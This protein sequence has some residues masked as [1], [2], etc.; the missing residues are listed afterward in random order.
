MKPALLVTILLAAATFTAVAAE[1]SAAPEPPKDPFVAAIEDLGSTDAMVRRRGAYRLGDL[2]NQKGAEPLIKALKD[3]N[4]FVRAGAISSLEK[5]RV[6]EAGTLIIKML[7]KD[8]NAQVR[9]QAA[10]AFANL[11]AEGKVKALIKALDDEADGVRYAAA[12]TLGSLRAQEAAKRLA[13]LLISP[14]E[15]SGM[16]RAAAGALRAIRSKETRLSLER[17]LAD[18]D[19][20]VRRE[21][22]QALAS[23]GTKESLPSLKKLL[24]DEDAQVRVLTAQTLAKFGDLSGITAVLG[25]LSNKDARVRQQAA[26]VVGRVG[27]GKEAIEALKEALK[28][29]THDGVQRS[30]TFAIQRLEAAEKRNKK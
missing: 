13:E 10:N 29:E 26:N 8:E 22:V 15:K 28:T 2:R 5:L 11:T 3:E 1:P 12:R 9:Q 7:L 25:L 20:Y 19:L 16:R 14:K 17:A 30:I 23:V 6:K 18:E 21:A 4:P 24:E 27:S